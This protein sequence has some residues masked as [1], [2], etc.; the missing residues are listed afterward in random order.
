VTAPEEVT[1][2][3]HAY[4]RFREHHPQADTSTILESWA[5]AEK[6]K[7][8]LAKTVLGRPGKSPPEWEEFRVAPDCR[9]MFLC[10]TRVGHVITYFRFGRA[11]EEFLRKGCPEALKPTTPYTRPPLKKLDPPRPGSIRQRLMDAS[12]QGHSLKVMEIGP[13]MTAV[14]GTTNKSR[15]ALIDASF[16]SS[17][18]EGRGLIYDYQ[19][20]E[21]VVSVTFP[22]TGR[23]FAELK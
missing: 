21:H 14:F 19:A 9:G 15:V 10:D 1:F 8:G 20:G 12:L 17:R 16:L 4:E 11:Q 18:Q 7:G 2:S 23:V 6:I 13:K 22:C 5:S 3:R